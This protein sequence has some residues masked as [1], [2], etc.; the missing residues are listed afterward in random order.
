MSLDQQTNQSK[1][2][3][4]FGELLCTKGHTSIMLCQ[5]KNCQKTPFICSTKNCECQ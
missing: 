5:N 1:M 2:S 4:D 3:F